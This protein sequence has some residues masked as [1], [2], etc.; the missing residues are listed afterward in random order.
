MAFERI[1]ALATVDVAGGY[2][3]ST[4]RAIRSVTILEHA[5]LKKIQLGALGH[6]G[7]RG[8]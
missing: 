1:C 8:L 6:V 2:F 3:H 4:I 5:C 7:L